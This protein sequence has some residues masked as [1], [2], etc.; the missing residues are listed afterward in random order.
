MD[1]C[2]KRVDWI[3]DKT[4]Y[5]VNLRQYTEAGTFK[6]FESHIPRI[7]EMGA[8]VLWF[9]PV[10]PIS[11]KGRKGSLGS[12]YACS[13][14]TKLNAEFGS[15]Q[16][17]L[18]LIQLAHKHEMKV[19]IDW[20]ANHTGRQHE[21]MDQH[22]NWFNQDAEGN[23][24]ERNGWEDVVDLNFENQDMR[25]ALIG[26]M[27]YWVRTF[28]IDGFRCDMAHLVPLDF[29]YSAR[30][31]CETIKPLFWLA[32][33]EDIAYHSVFDATYAWSWM[34]ATTKVENEESGVNEIYNILHDYAQYPQGAYKLFFTSNHDENTWNGTEYEKYGIAAKAWAVFTFMWKGLPLLYSGQEL[35]NHKRLAF[36]DKDKI[37][38]TH[39]PLLGAFYKTLIEL[40]KN[41]ACIIDG[42]SFNLPTSNNQVM[43]FLR[44]DHAHEKKSEKESGK[45]IV[46]VLLN[47]SHQVQKVQVEHAYLNGQFLNAFS[48]L[49]YSF[50]KQEGFELMPGDY[51]VYVKASASI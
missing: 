49:S 21:W 4:I 10:T 40:R 50:N 28:N 44:Y 7:K 17:F 36:F 11:E 32:E 23:F 46:L 38:W 18:S 6:A 51:L 37:E 9:M 48:G 33:C 15:E 19:M 42:D 26:A 20:V 30:K 24:T 31:A 25:A 3:K 8:E 39:Q 1:A 34:H 22:P 29:W 12:Y 2:F 13:S 41:Y 45:Q 14:Y 47:F 35:P 43:A 27:Q 16:D 5:E